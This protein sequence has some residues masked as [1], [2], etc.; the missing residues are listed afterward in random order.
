M[1]S[2]VSG[3]GSLLIGDGATR[4]CPQAGV[5]EGV[6][7]RRAVGEFLEF[8]SMLEPISAHPG[9][10]QGGEMTTHAQT[11]TEIARQGTDIGARRTVHLDVQVDEGPVATH[12][13]HI[14]TLDTHA[15][16]GEFD[17]LALTHQLKWSRQVSR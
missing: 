1:P 4:E 7:Q 5:I 10:T 3:I 13:Q 11:G 16:R 17:L 14:E 2:A 8:A 9:A 15:A 6:A 12:R